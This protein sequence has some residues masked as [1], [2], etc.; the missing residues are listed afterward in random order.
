VLFNDLQPDL[1]EVA[2]RPID[3][4]LKSAKDSFLLLRIHTFICGPNVEYDEPDDPGS[5][6]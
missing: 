6:A 5:F 1:K 2:I 4:F 3:R